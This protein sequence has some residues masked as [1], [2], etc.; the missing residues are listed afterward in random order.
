[1][2]SLPNSAFQLIGTTIFASCPH[3]GDSPP[4]VNLPDC[5]IKSIASHRLSPSEIYLNNI[6]HGSVPLICLYNFNA[7]PPPWMTLFVRS[8]S[9]HP[10][11]CSCC[12]YCVRNCWSHKY[13]N[14]VWPIE[15]CSCAKLPVSITRSLICWHCKNSI[16]SA[17]NVL[18][19]SPFTSGE[20]NWKHANLSFSLIKSSHADVISFNSVDLLYAVLCWNARGPSTGITDA[21]QNGN[22]WIY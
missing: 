7:K 10:L 20:R 6:Q 8:H 17:K 2:G 5:F 21:C 15:C 22:V 13:M 1:M 19:G 11:F 14:F 12:W 16:K 3:S 4:I 9:I 18:N